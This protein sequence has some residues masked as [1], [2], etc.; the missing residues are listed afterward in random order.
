MSNAEI[1]GNLNVSENTVK[2]HVK[3]E[4]D[5]LHMKNRGEAVA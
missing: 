3:K 1:G 5:K 2:T 4:L